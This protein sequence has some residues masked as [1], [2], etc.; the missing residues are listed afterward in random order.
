M[1]F[2]TSP[3]KVGYFSKIEEI[4][5]YCPDCSNDLEVKIRF[6][7]LALYNIYVSVLF[8]SEPNYLVAQPNSAACNNGKISFKGFNS[9]A[10]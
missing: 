7:N 6:M 9:V 10:R 3:S 2:L 8:I 1:I 4:F 5:P